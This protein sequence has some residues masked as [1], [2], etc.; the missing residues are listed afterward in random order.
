MEPVADRQ[1]SERNKVNEDERKSDEQNHQNTRR[2][3]FDFYLDV[4][5]FVFLNE[6]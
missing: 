1:R 3:N 4:Q 2:P 6:M 5:I